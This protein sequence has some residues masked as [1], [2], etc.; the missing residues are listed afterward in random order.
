MTILVEPVPSTMILTMNYT[1]IKFTLWNL[2]H[3]FPHWQVSRQDV[4]NRCERQAD[5]FRHFGLWR[6]HAPASEDVELEEDDVSLD[7]DSRSASVC[8][9]FLA[10]AFSKRAAALAT[11]TLSSFCRMTGSCG[12][13]FFCAICRRT[14]SLMSPGSGPG[15]SQLL[16][17]V[18]KPRLQA[19][20]TISPCSSGSA[21][22]RSSTV[23]C[24]R[25]SPTASL[26]T[27]FVIWIPGGC[28]W[29]CVAL[30]Q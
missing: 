6:S 3:K 25:G 18:Q 21:T 11:R 7:E 27:E 2:G 10:P 19:M 1:I 12:G 29:R 26:K 14:S 13:R 30:R 16:S 28:A 5:I 24:R 4:S 20:L 9:L 17:P 8:R 23:Q 22:P 15:L